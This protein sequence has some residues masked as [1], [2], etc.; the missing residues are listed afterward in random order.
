MR[1]GA[2]LQRDCDA[3]ATR[4]LRATSMRRTRV[5][6]SRK[7]VE[8]HTFSALEALRDALYKYSTTTTTT[9]TTTCNRCFTVSG[10]ADNWYLVPQRIVR[11][12][13][14]HVNNKWIGGAA[15]R[16]TAPD[17]AFIP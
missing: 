8:S 13:I 3:I 16:Y 5:A 14:A 1:L 11:P 2:T 7:T 17:W 15:S 12:S 10:E 4:L 9:T 6:R